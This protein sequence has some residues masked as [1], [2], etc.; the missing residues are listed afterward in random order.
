MK[1]TVFIERFLFC[2]GFGQIP[3]KEIGLLQLSLS[4]MEE[5]IENITH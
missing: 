3:I 1:E 4:I 5:N 2:F